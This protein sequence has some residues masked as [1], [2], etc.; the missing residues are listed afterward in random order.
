V[1]CPSLVVC[2][3]T[4]GKRGRVEGLTCGDIFNFKGGQAQVPAQVDCCS[5]S[6]EMGNLYIRVKS[7][8]EHNGAQDAKLET[9]SQVSWPLLPRFPPDTHGALP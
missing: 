7:S 5:A 9:L 4:A 3:V 2:K 8:E 1:G 6:E